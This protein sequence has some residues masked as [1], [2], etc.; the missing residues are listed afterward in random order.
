VSREEETTRLPGA[1]EG[2]CRIEVFGEDLEL[3]GERAVWWCQRKI[4]FVTDLH[5]GQTAPARQGGLPDSTPNGCDTLLR[6]KK[7]VCKYSPTECIILG[8]LIDAKA[9]F[10]ERVQG[11]LSEFFAEVATCRWRLIKGNHDRQTKHWPAHWPLM[12]EGEEFFLPPF[13]L[14]HYPPGLPEAAERLELNLDL[15][16]EDDCFFLAGHL[17]PAWRDD[18]N[19]HA[20]E[21]SACYWLTS[22]GLVLPPFG[23]YAKTQ[24]IARQPGDRVF[25]I[26][27]DEVIE[28]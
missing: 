2:S 24:S 12:I 18:A 11:A 21:K 15:K 23:T 3:L 19:K 20:G 10:N 26:A 6:L 4:L 9:S 27:A 1:G 5:L 22:Q 8:D 13:R 16:V 17:H 25:V 14:L 28:V 7:L